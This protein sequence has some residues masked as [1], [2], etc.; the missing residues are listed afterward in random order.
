[1]DSGPKGVR[2]DG[3]E[4]WIQ[5]LDEGR[6]VADPRN[7]LSG[8]TVPEADW[9]VM[10]RIFRI[11]LRQ[12]APVDHRSHARSRAG[13]TNHLPCSKPDAASRKKTA[14]G[15]VCRTVRRRR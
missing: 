6:V 7:V 13:R 2:F 12:Y 5:L 9:K 14:L 4:G 10:D 15:S 3:D 8:L 1:M 11:S